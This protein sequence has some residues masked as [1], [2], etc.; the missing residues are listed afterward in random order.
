[1]KRQEVLLGTSPGAVLVL[2]GERLS[3]IAARWRLTAKNQ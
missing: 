2:T 1:M 3:L